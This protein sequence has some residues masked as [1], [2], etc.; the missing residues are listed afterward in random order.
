MLEQFRKR[1]PQGNFLRKLV[2]HR[3]GYY[4]VTVTLIANDRLQAVGSASAPN[5]T[6]A[7]TAATEQAMLRLELEANY[8]LDS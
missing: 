8:Q 1:Y 4:L 7:I 5:P 3:D 2:H 6:V